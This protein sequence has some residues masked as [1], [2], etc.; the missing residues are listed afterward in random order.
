MSKI[1]DQF[2]RANLPIEYWKRL[3]N[4]FVKNDKNYVKYSVNSRKKSDYKDA[5]NI[6]FFKNKQ[7]HN[8]VPKDFENIDVM[9][10]SFEKYFNVKKVDDFYNEQV[11]PALSEISSILNMS[12]SDADDYLINNGITEKF[13]QTENKKDINN[14]ITF[15]KITIE[16][17]N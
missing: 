1:V 7:L 6:Y 5:F 17:Q 14:F 13:F 10:K 9:I 16:L 15:I 12:E 4:F 11:I 8:I 3:N 2:L